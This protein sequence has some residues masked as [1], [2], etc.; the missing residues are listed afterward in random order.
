MKMSRN[1][2]DLYRDILSSLEV[3]R[4]NQRLGV[5]CLAQISVSLEEFASARNSWEKKKTALDEFGVDTSLI[6]VEKWQQEERSSSIIEVETQ[7]CKCRELLKNQHQCVKEFEK[8][9]LALEEQ[10]ATKPSTELSHILE[11][12][13]NCF[14]MYKM[15]YK[16]IF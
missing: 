6:N 7:L 11:L 3:W 12:T 16:V 13:Q 4:E 15:E 1:R 9:K 5:A 8:S 10:N 2:K 14:D